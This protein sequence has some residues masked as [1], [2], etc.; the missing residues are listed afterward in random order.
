MLLS[1]CNDLKSI[2]FRKMKNII[3]DCQ[4]FKTNPSICLMSFKSCKS[5]LPVAYNIYV[6]VQF[7]P[8]FKFYSPLFQTHHHTLPY[9]KTKEIKFKP[10]IKLNHNSVNSPR[11]SRSLLDIATIIS[12]FSYM[13]TKS[14]GYHSLFIFSLI[15]IIKPIFFPK[16]ETFFDSWYSYWDI[17]AHILPL[18]RVTFIL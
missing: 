8:W 12:L 9:P 6:F 2:I 1:I 15:I 5:N 7:Y 18:I 17:F 14:P 11:L 4:I 3:F 16:F 10:R 13:V